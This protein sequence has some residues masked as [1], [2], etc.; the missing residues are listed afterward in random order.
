M[1]ETSGFA[2]LVVCYCKNTIANFIFDKIL[3]DKFLRNILNYFVNIFKILE[4]KHI[5]L[6]NL[7]F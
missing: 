3:F 2:G 5:I 7:I 1:G 4:N 6:N